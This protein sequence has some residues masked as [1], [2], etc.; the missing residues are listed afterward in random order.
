MAKSKTEKRKYEDILFEVKDNVAWVT[1]VPGLGWS[2]PIVSGD[3]VFLGVNALDEF[4]MATP[5]IAHSSLFIR[6][7]SKLYRIRNGG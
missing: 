6:T 7:A 1:D 2:S 3:S 5:A 4:T